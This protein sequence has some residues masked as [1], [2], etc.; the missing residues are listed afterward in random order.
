MRYHHA[1]LLLGSSMLASA[2]AAAAAVPPVLTG[3][4]SAQAITNRCNMYVARSTAL[5]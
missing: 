3:A 2:P 5:L 1:F 4:P